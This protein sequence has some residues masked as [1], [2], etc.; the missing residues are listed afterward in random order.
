MSKIITQQIYKKGGNPTNSQEYKELE[1]DH[2]DL[3]DIKKTL[4]DYFVKMAQVVKIKKGDANYTYKGIYE[5][6]EKK[7]GKPKKG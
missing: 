5:A 2:K 3:K 4:D 7:I 6:V 1:K